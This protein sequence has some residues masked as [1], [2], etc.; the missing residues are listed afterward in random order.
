MTL[1]SLTQ[2]LLPPKVELSEIVEYLNNPSKFKQ[3][4]SGSKTLYEKNHADSANEMRVRRK[5]VNGVCASAR[6][7]WK[8]W[9][10]RTCISI[11]CR[12]HVTVLFPCQEN[13]KYTRLVHA[14]HVVHC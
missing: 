13:G 1:V 7:R 11:A 8:S 12:V 4:L 10:D 9:G 6:G 2:S 14:Y 3:E 5:E